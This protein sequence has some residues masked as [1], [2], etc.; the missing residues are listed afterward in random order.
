MVEFRLLGTF[1]AADADGAVP[2]GGGKQRALL[3]YLLLHRNVAI[4]RDELIDVLW[5]ADPPAS[6][7]HALDV[8]VSRLR[9]SLGVDGLLEAQGGALRLNVADDS[10]DTARFE[11]LLASA[12]S[13]VSA[14][15]RLGTLEEALG[16]WRG[17]A[18]ADVLGEEFARHE[19]DR[20]EEER[21]AAI[22][23]R[24][25][26][27]LELGRHE[28]AVGGLGALAAEQPLRERPRRLLMLALYRSGRQSDA[29][30][31][32][33]ETARLLREE[34]GLDPSDELR[35]LEAAILRRDPA[36]APP[37][38]GPA[39]TEAASTAAVARAPR[40]RRRRRAMLVLAVVAVVAAGATL[41][42][43][44][45]TG[46]GSGG[47]A[48]SAV[49]HLSAVAIDPA[50]E[51]VDSIVPL[52]S[53]PIAALAQGDTVWVANSVDRTLTRID[54]RTQTLGATFGLPAAPTSL[55]F[56]AGRLWVASFDKRHS[57][58]AVDPRSGETVLSIPLH[59]PGLGVF[60]AQGWGANGVAF[61]SGSVWV[62]VG[63]S[64]L[65]RLTP[66]GSIE[67]TWIVG[68]TP[69]SIAPGPDGVWTA[70]VGP[71]QVIPVD[72]RT[73]TLGRPV[74]VGNLATGSEARTQ[75]SCTMI[76][77]LGS[78][79]VPAYNGSSGLTSAVYRI[80]PGHGVVEA[81]V[82]VDGSPCGVAVGHGKVWIANPNNS[83]VDVI[84]PRTNALRKI[85]FGAP[86]VAIAV[87]RR[88]VW[89]MTN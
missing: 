14:T 68:P 48:G 81:V 24:F 21:L 32:Y 18:L 31:V 84:D 47:E 23:Q 11:R 15:E 54:D 52:R 78:L 80:D 73:N 86:P 75:L 41:A 3:A 55:A 29:L 12:R 5:P 59:E 45:L 85:V 51:R 82:P 76:V 20:L 13:A 39:A 1:E 6:A 7:A 44:N 88:H 67:Q 16:L 83:E 66:S 56:G 36:L 8:Y 4:P 42:A 17:R 57:L 65:F 63:P 74:D 62:T 33:R 71:A 64:G 60:S 43:V 2:V 34:L 38:P 49:P 10:V 28:E 69:T 50:S 40:P 72:P 27:M 87:A 30:D 35:A 19:S 25:E 89:V 53:Q 9:K 22:E 77:A 37:G 61:G 79:W 26:V 58:T 46:S 70:L